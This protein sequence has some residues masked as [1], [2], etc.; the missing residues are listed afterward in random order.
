MQAGKLYYSCSLIK[1]KLNLLIKSWWLLFSS[2][3]TL[4]CRQNYGEMCKWV[5]KDGRG[6]QRAEPHGAGW[7]E[8]A[9]AALT[10]L[11][12]RVPGTARVGSRLMYFSHQ[13]QYWAFV[14]NL[15]SLHLILKKKKRNKTNHTPTFSSCVR[16]T[17]VWTAK[18]HSG[19]LR[20]IRTHA[21]AHFYRKVSKIWM[22]NLKL[23]QLRV[24]S[25]G[26]GIEPEFVYLFVI[27]LCILGQNT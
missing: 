23:K 2:R 13:P 18:V 7:K 8:H 25:N 9:T 21:R 26:S 12:W 16:L 5:V 19:R 24:H 3:K 27:I 10:L 14:R 4:Y 11:I 1:G 15:A 20:L 22:A 6:R 17:S